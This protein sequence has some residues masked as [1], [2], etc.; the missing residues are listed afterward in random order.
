MVI[1]LPKTRNGLP[2]L[3][4]RF[5]REGV[6]AY[7]PELRPTRVS[8]WLPRFT[9]TRHYELSLIL[10]KLGMTLAFSEADF[11]GITGRPGL[12]IDQVFHK[13]FVETTER[14]TTAAA[15]TA[16]VMVGISESPTPE[17][18]VDHPFLFFV[19]DRRSGAVL[20]AGRIVAPGG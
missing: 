20:F 4:K 6:G 2:D 16:V 18:R 3:E 5:G 1:V 14:G 11:S 10:K 19:R 8:L 13:A 7:V 15:A 9:A 12:H 17:M